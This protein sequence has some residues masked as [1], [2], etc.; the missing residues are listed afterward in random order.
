M[1]FHTWSIH[2]L[3]SIFF[4]LLPLCYHGG[5]KKV[6]VRGVKSPTASVISPDCQL[7]NDLHVQPPE[8]WH[9]RHLQR[10]LKLRPPGQILHREPEP[11]A[12]GAQQGFPS[13]STTYRAWCKSERLATGWGHHSSFHPRAFRVKD[14]GGGEGSK[15]EK[16]TGEKGKSSALPIKYVE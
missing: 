15:E 11:W 3:P 1:R 4:S 16:Q 10:A 6:P 2:T 13:G 12:S 9:C 7:R 14:G 8:L 5:G